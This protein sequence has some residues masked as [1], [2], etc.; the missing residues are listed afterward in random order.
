MRFAYHLGKLVTESLSFAVSTR[1]LTVALLI[2]AGLAMVAL[3]LTAQVVAPLALY[4][5]A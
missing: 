1:K 2:V 5:F 4:P 3:S